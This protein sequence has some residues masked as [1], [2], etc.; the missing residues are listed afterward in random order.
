M[1]TGV[2]SQNFLFKALIYYRQRDAVGRETGPRRSPSRTR[3]VFGRFF[4]MTTVLCGKAQHG[5]A[6]DSEDPACAS[7][8]EF[9]HA[10]LC[11][12]RPDGNAG[13]RAAHK[14]QTRPRRPRSRC[15]V[16]A[17]FLGPRRCLPVSLRG[18][19]DPMP[20]GP[21]PKEPNPGGRVPS[22]RPW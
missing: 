1:T 22:P 17:R 20:P 13:D 14:H 11:H 7:P 16:S 4:P 15:L 3:C 6:H 10:P 12:R 9:L 2:I 21:L 5:L 18:G 8:R 19:R